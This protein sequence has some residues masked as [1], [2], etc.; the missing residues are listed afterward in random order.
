MG[1]KHID[2]NKVNYHLHRLDTSESELGTVALNKR[3]TQFVKLYLKFQSKFLSKLLKD[4]YIKD[5]YLII[6]PMKG[7]GYSNVYI[8]ITKNI[9]Y[10]VKE[11]MSIIYR[12][13]FL[14]SRVYLEYSLYPSPA[15]EPVKLETYRQFFTELLSL[16]QNILMY[17]SQF[18]ISTKDGV[19][20]TFVDDQ[21]TFGQ[22]QKYL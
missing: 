16:Y 19:S 8:L 18:L 2:L 14:K 5:G 22:I 21:V 12:Y 20:K 4:N 10:F 6:V 3:Q 7:A 11:E 17:P 15:F 13:R 1:F 9:F